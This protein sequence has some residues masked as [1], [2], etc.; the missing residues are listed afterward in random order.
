MNCGG[1]VHTDSER[2]WTEF[3]VDP[4]RLNSVRFVV[5]YAGYLESKLWLDLL[6]S[7]LQGKPV[8]T[9]ITN[10]GTPACWANGRTFVFWSHHPRQPWQT[11]DW[12]NEQQ[13]TL[14]PAEYRRMIECFFVEG[15]GNFCDPA[16]WQALIDPHHN[17]LPPHSPQAVYV[18]LD[19]AT[20]PGGDDCALIGVYNE[21]GK[22]KVAF[23]QVWK[24]K[25][26]KE[27]LKLTETVLP[28]LLRVKKQYQLKGVWFD[29]FQAL[30]L[31][32]N[33]RHSGVRTVEVSQTHATR[34]PKDTALLEMVNNQQLVLYPDK[35]LRNATSG[36]NAKE[37]GNGLIFLK[38]A[39]GRAKIDLLIALS[40]V[41]DQ[42][43]FNK[44]QPVTSSYIDWWAPWHPPVK[45]PEP[46][47][48]STEIEQL[49][50][51]YGDE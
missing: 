16:D 49:L 32:E 30:Q 26:R 25:T 2:L 5:G 42:V 15:I 41:A 39:S 1:Y 45:P 29:P 7:G 44:P 17:P 4:T 27:R 12:L 18:G 28:Y 22:V 13:R 37:L 40:N 36:A 31:A 51:E 35:E 33:L 9:D 8:L 23:H 10:D 3:K 38:K 21:G 24:G 43:S 11:P 6:N 34:G 19:L 20:A 50:N 47:R 14:R 48:T 46:V